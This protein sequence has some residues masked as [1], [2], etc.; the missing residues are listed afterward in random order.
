[1]LARVADVVATEE[2]GDHFFILAAVGQGVVHVHF[3]FRAQGE[4]YAEVVEILPAGGL[5]AFEGLQGFTGGDLLSE[6]G[7]A[8]EIV[9]R[10]ED[11]AWRGVGCAQT[12]HFGDGLGPAVGLHAHGGE[13]EIKTAGY[14]VKMLLGRALVERAIGAGHLREDLAVEDS[15]AECGGFLQFDDR[16]EGIEGVVACE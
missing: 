3:T 16:R 4:G 6:V 12:A 13:V 9:G 8:E 15:G 7:V 14:G 1:M 2:A 5:E 11:I 10:A